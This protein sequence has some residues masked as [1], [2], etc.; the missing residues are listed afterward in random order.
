[1]R[2]GNP[3]APAAAGGAGGAGDSGGAG[4]PGIA[5]DNPRFLVL[6]VA[7]VLVVGTRAGFPAD[8][9][10]PCFAASCIG[11]AQPSQSVRRPQLL[12]YEPRAAGG[13]RR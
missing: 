5:G 13:A 11:G 9:I 7:A 6:F 4:D 12:P 2:P 3:G 1:M 8:Q 10:H